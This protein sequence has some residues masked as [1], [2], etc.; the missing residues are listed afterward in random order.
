MTEGVFQIN[1]MILNLR[2]EQLKIAIPE[3]RP[4]TSNKRFRQDDDSNNYT[5]PQKLLKYTKLDNMK[6]QQEE[7]DNVDYQLAKATSLL[8]IGHSKKL[9]N[10]EVAHRS[11]SI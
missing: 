10:N 3:S 7:I 4:R 1:K 2:K 9:L 6:E 5:T 8:N 11:Q